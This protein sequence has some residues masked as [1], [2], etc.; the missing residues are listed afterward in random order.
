M[1]RRSRTSS[2]G[3]E[4]SRR[5]TPTEIRS[6]SESGGASALRERS[7]LDFAEP[8]AN[9]RAL[10]FVFR[11]FDRAVRGVDGGRR[12]SQQK[13]RLRFDDPREGRLDGFER[14]TDRSAGAFA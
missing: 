9:P 1:P 10:I 13:Q 7:V 5:S 3:K 6:S 4:R 11:E 14:G 8:F 12:V 2:S